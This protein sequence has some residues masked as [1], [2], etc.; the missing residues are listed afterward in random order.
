MHL[1]M[2]FPHGSIIPRLLIGADAQIHELLLEDMPRNMTRFHRAVDEVLTK[3]K[4]LTQ[5]DDAQIR[6]SLLGAIPRNCEIFDRAVE[7]MLEKIQES[8][9]QE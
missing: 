7:E 1:V 2:L 6:D 9:Q 4:E 8:A 3:I 5:L